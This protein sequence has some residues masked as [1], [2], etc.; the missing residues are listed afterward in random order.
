MLF[1]NH[2]NVTSGDVT[3]GCYPLLPHNYDLFVPIYYL[4]VHVY[5]KCHLYTCTSIRYK[6]IAEYLDL[7][8]VK[9]TNDLLRKNNDQPTNNIDVSCV[10]TVGLTHVLIAL[11]SFLIKIFHFKIHVNKIPD[12]YSYID[13]YQS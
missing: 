9:N 7:N 11:S 10:E 12:N 4:H 1:E 13:I 6:I 2:W 3:S 5:E 8:N